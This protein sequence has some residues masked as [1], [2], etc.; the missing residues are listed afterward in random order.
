MTTTPD[1]NPSVN[2]T[3]SGEQE[4]SLLDLFTVLL[5]HKRL[6]TLLPLGIGALA[7][8]MTFLIKPSFT[9]TT[10]ML[11]PQQQQGTGLAALL[12]AAGGGGL[13]SALGSVGGLKNP[14]DQWIGLLKSRSIADALVDRFGLQELYEAKYR[15]Q[16]RQALEGSTKI[17]AGKDNLI[18][19]EVTDHSPDRAAK[20]ANAYVEELQRLTNTLALTEA[21]QRR[22]YFEKQ[23]TEA[24]K[25]LIKAE[26]QLKQVGVSQDV[27][28]TTPEA[29]VGRVAQVQAAVAAQEVKVSVMR[30]GLT[31][32]SPDLQLALAELA[33]LRN[34]LR[35]AERDG[36]SA[37]QGS[38]DY[39]A[40][41]REFKYYETLFELLARQF[42][43]A[44]ADEARDGALIQVVDVAQAPEYKSKPKRGLIA[45][46]TTALAFTLCAAYILAR[47]AL[48]DYSGTPE[49]KKRLAK[50]RHA[51]SIGRRSV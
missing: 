29:A 38:S 24:R 34:Q 36:P 13:A 48:R 40:R 4:I 30:N 21:S 12:G 5:S 37:Q 6:L 2:D 32:H 7:L 3:V 43:M 33:A 49:G 39:V 35:S 26:T 17:T 50:V 9:A 1:M 16:A 47:Q 41:Y 51:W 44:K 28:K 46:L 25:N 14:S 11:P 31:E 27:M 8:G 23:L 45:V 42:E 19:I 10:Q 22:L 20:I 18:D 15:F